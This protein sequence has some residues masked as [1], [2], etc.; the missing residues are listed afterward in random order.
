MDK[1]ASA[2][3]DSPVVTLPTLR[4]LGRSRVQVRLRYRLARGSDYPD[5]NAR[6][7]AAKYVEKDRGLPQNT[8]DPL[9]DW[10]IDED[11]RLDRQNIEAAQAADTKF[12]D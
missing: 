7:Y 9:I 4:P 6:T 11:E 12:G 5:A 3:A 8:L 10:L 1:A 2:E